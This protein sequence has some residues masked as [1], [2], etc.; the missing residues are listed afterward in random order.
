MHFSVSMTV[1]NSLHLF[2]GECG[3]TTV[4]VFVVRHDCVL[5][6]DT[7]DNCIFRSRYRCSTASRSAQCRLLWICIPY[8]AHELMVSHPHS[9]CRWVFIAFRHSIDTSKLVHVN[10]LRSSVF[11][12]LVVIIFKES[13]PIRRCDPGWA[14]NT[15][16]SGMTGGISLRVFLLLIRPR[17]LD[18]PN[19]G[20]PSVRHGE[21]F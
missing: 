5:V 14:V 4:L 6:P 21:S 7:N 9:C 15:V 1:Q 16:D 19:V 20:I 8:S 12:I 2:N 13:G 17:I 18:P 10:L 11:T 3:V